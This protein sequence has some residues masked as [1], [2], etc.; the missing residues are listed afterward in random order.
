MKGMLVFARDNGWSQLA[1]RVSGA[2]VR[3]QRD[4]LTARHLRAPGFRAGRSP[5]LLGLSH[6]RVGED[7]HAGDGLWLEAVLNYGEG[8]ERQQF[9]P[10]LTVGRSARLSD[11]VHIGCLDR[12][13]IGDHLL[14][15]SRVL[16]SDHAHGCYRG[17][18]GS[19]PGVPP[20]GRALHSAGPVRLGSNV[21]LGDG[22]AVLAGAD[23]GDGCVI[24]ANSVVTGIIPPGCVAVGSPASVIRRWNVLR[25]EWL[26]LE[27]PG[28]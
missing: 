7:F 16:I 28:V 4:W 2:A 3:R 13:T 22:V 18:G 26:P 27:E 9:T 5:R 20:A 1:Q 24:G 23:I 8:L 6:M 14:A 19:D 10:L 11:G 25:R 12:I 15:G 21:W 17:A